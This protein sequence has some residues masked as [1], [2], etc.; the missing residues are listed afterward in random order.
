MADVASPD[1]SKPG[2][3][4][5]DLFLSRIHASRCRGQLRAS[6]VSGRGQRVVLWVIDA[7]LL[8]TLRPIHPVADTERLPTRLRDP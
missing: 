4:G 2:A 3:A 7:E 5:P 6:V 1:T 8:T